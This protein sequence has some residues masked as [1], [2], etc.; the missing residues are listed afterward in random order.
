M[1][2]YWT[3]ERR[4]DPEPTRKHIHRHV[5]IHVYAVHVYAQ[6]HTKNPYSLKTA[7]SSDAS[8]TV[9]G[10]RW[11]IRGNTK[12]CQ[13]VRLMSKQT[14]HFA[15]RVNRFRVFPTVQH[16]SIIVYNRSNCLLNPVW[17]LS[18]YRDNR[19]TSKYCRQSPVDC[20]W[21]DKHL[22]SIKQLFHQFEIEKIRWQSELGFQIFNPLT[23]SVF[24]G[25]TFALASFGVPQLHDYLQL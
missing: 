6:K 1:R 16:S 12:L 11:T 17:D 18:C 20:V 14:E 22:L 3:R 15:A 23:P 7:Q 9:T 5:S 2:G 13:V 21:V 4:G 19:H 24:L 8:G 10:S 25:T